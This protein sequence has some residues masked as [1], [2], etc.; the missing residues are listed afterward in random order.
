MVPFVGMLWRGQQQR[1]GEIDPIVVMRSL[2][3]S[4]VS[5]V[6]LIFVVV[7]VLGHAKLGHATGVSK[8]LALGSV[9]WG[10]IMVGV[11]SRL[12]RVRLDARDPLQTAGSYR[13]NLFTKIAFAESSALLGFVL[14]IVSGRWWVYGLGWV[15]S[16]LG[17]AIGAPG[18]ADIQRRQEELR[19]AGRG[20]DLLAAL[21]G[22]AGS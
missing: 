5:A 11:V 17:F 4:F 6:C 10:V 19:V 22:E 8:W 2:Y 3:L 1:N 16:I 13:T 14:F 15:F 9:A 21:R 12:R 7:G 20:I 18:R